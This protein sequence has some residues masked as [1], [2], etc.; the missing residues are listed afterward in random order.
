LWIADRTGAD[1]RQVTHSDGVYKS[2]PRWSPDGTRLA[3]VSRT[4]D[5][6]A[7]QLIDIAT[8]HT[9]TILSDTTILVAPSW[10]HDGRRLYVG[11]PGAGSWQILAVDVH[12]GHAE[13][14]GIERATPLP[15]HRRP[16]V[17][18]HA[19][20]QPGLRRRPTTGGADEMVI[21]HFH[22]EDWPNWG[23][24]DAG[25]FYLTWP[26]DDDPQLV[27]ADADGGHPRP[28][29]RLAQ[30]AWSGVAVSRDGASVIYAHADRREANIGGI[31]RLLIVECVKLLIDCDSTCSESAINN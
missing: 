18:L 25:L 7:L 31:G 21:P 29:T 8:G 1:A 9:T 30:H 3:F 5:G 6:A 22:V 12:T 11:S 24:V 16:V 17:V 10:S 27:L 19:L 13:P 2:V 4:A 15:N 28:L 14:M 23:V 20:D 26:D